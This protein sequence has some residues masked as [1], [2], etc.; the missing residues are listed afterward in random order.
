MFSVMRLMPKNNRIFVI[1]CFSNHTAKS[2]NHLVN[3]AHQEN[4]KTEVNTNLKEFVSM[5]NK[6]ISGFIFL[7]MN[8]CFLQ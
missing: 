1:V 7:F 8:I 5:N 6:Q 3:A 2:S 4:S